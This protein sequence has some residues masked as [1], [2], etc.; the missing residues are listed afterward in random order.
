[1]RKRRALTEFAKIRERIV[2]GVKRLYE[3]NSPHLPTIFHYNMTMSVNAPPPSS[4][5]ALWLAVSSLTSSLIHCNALPIGRNSG[6]NVCVREQFPGKI[7]LY[8]ITRYF[9]ILVDVKRERKQSH[10]DQSAT[11]SNL[12]TLMTT[13]NFANI[14]R[15]WNRV[16][17]H[18]E[19]CVAAVRMTG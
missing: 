1:M 14:F 10:S 7:L 8:F 19:I 4:S 6:H 17:L 13:V 5:L 3:F 2:V 12:N 9:L 15:W 11:P 18:E 16:G